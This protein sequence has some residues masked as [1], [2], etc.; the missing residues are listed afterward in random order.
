MGEV[1]AHIILSNLGD[2]EAGITSDRKALALFENVAKANPNNVQ[3]QLNVAMMH[4]ILSFS[5]LNDA[6]GQKELEQA[7][8]ITDHVLKTA[9]NNAAALSE[10]AVHRWH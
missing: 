7:I 4:R 1:R 8:A 5:S 6:T 3:D 2:V 10:S 9:P